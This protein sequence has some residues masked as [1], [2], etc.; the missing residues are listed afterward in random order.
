MKITMP[1][2]RLLRPL[3]QVSTVVERRQTLPILA[4]VFL[5]LD[6]G[7][8]R[9]SGTDLEVE[10]VSEIPDVAGTTGMCTITARKLLEICRALPG[11][12]EF[13]LEVKGDR[14]TLKSG[15][16]RFT[17]QTLPAGDFPRLQTEDWDFQVDVPAGAFRRLLEKTQFA[18]A[19]QDVRYYLNGLLVELGN[20]RIRTV[21]TDGHRLARSEA[22][23]EG[24]DRAHQ[25][26]LPRKAVLELSRVVADGDRPVRLEFN[27][28][29]CRVSLDDL[30]F[31]TKLIDGRFPDYNNVIPKESPIRLRLGRESFHD[32]LARASILTNEKFRGVRVQLE[33]GRLT[34]T[35]HNPEHEE[36]TDELAVEYE[37]EAVEIG[38]NVAYVMDALKALDADEVELGMRDGNSSCTLVD[39]DGAGETLYLV[40]PMRL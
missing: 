23:V 29:H 3:T 34:V 37:G 20:G 4:N 33:P 22:A 28:R 15:R 19:Q 27:P 14:A 16:S 24:A 21:A 32:V 40:M 17:L 1:C 25:V 26:I 12:A 2:S 18:M 6:D 36:A 30:V 7:L 10:I 38:F 39:A 11:D 5:S 9:L 35:A 31:T 13:D 8:L